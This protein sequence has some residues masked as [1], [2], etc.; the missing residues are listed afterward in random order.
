LRAFRPHVREARVTQ[1]SAVYGLVSTR[2]NEIVVALVVVA[3]FLERFERIRDDGSYPV[4]PIPDLFFLAAVGIFAA[5]VAFDLRQG[6]LSL[7]P[8]GWKDLVLAGFVALLG[9]LSLVSVVTQPSDVTSGVQVLKTF[10]HVVVLLGAALLLGHALSRELVAHAMRV[11]FVGAVAIAGL[12]I[13][14]AVDQN[15]VTLGIADALDLVSRAGAGGFVRPCSV[16]SEPAYLGYASLGGLVIGLSLLS[17]RHKIAAAIGCGVCVAGLLLAAAIG[18]LAVAVPL[19]VYALV[20]RRRLF[21]RQAALTLAWSILVAAAIWFLT[22][23]GDTVGYRAESISTGI[24][25]G[26][27]DSEASLDFR[28]KL[29]RE[30][31]DVWKIAP[32]TGV[33]LG[34]SRRHLSGQI[35]V[36]WAP[37]G[38][39]AAFNSANAYVNLLGEAGPLAVVALAVVLLALWWK[40]RTAPPRL[41]ELTRVFIVLVALEFFIINPLI[42]PLVWFWAAQRLAMQDE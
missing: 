35:D 21:P 32:L 26:S 40:S 30:S 11:Y 7:R 14:Q 36:S 20:V 33:G 12:G 1:E 37:P 6:H 23:V 25:T 19:G 31:I 27:S 15:L 3:V 2:S 16:F 18:P 5:K 4:L 13:V 38:A 28:T 29:N 24:A 10:T 34:N 9:A 8:L 42:M 41:D 22:P 39:S 17:E